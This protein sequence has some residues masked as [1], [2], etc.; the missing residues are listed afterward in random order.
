ME[1]KVFNLG[2][3]INK[4]GQQERGFAYEYYN[5]HGSPGSRA[6]PIHHMHCAFCGQKY[7]ARKNMVKRCRC[8]ACQQG[9]SSFIAPK[10]GLKSPETLEYRL[11]PEAVANKIK[12]CSFHGVPPVVALY[13]ASKAVSS[14][15]LDLAA[16]NITAGGGSD[17]PDLPKSVTDKTAKRAHKI[18]GKF[19]PSERLKKQIQERE[20]GTAPKV[21]V[22]GKV[23][24][25]DAVADEI[26][27]RVDADPDGFNT[28]EQR[29]AEAVA[30]SVIE[31]D[32]ATGW[33]PEAVDGAAQVARAQYIR[34]RGADAKVWNECSDATRDVW[35]KIV[36]GA[37]DYYNDMINKDL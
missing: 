21:R 5:A 3:R 16:S 8:C 34:A 9:G 11:S 14:A 27:S 7:F 26:G 36:T 13:A 1:Q 33:T 24:D 18:T 37:V 19:E 17:G 31:D 15:I 4:Y 35:R 30:D 6:Y 28:P 29:R 32:G 12:D 25:A 2:D 20:A 23:K 10:K 22:E